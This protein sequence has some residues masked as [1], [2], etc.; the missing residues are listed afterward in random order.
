MLCQL[1]SNAAVMICTSISLTATSDCCLRQQANRHLL[2]HSRSRVVQM[3]KITY[4]Y[5]KF[6]IP[7]VSRT[8]SAY[9]LALCFYSMHFNIV[10]LFTISFL[11]WSFPFMFSTYVL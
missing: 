11:K 3:P 6:T 10:T 5:K 2:S 1:T 8:N 7:G 4:I 9:N